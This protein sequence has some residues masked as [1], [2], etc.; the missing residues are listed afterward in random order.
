MNKYIVEVL[1]DDGENYVLAP[2]NV[3]MLHELLDFELFDSEELAKEAWKK[4]KLKHP[5]AELYTW[6]INNLAKS[7]SDALEVLYNQVNGSKRILDKYLTRDEIIIEGMFEN[8]K[9]Y[10]TVIDYNKKEALYFA[11]DSSLNCHVD[12]GE[13]VGIF[14]SKGLLRDIVINLFKAL[15]ADSWEV[16]DEVD[17]IKDVDIWLD[18]E[19]Q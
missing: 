12:S 1:G 6:L 15:D 4:Y 7:K 10:F 19:E 3:L 13:F 11:I 14:I 16:I 18:W 2:N 9:T 8:N 5:E 17:S